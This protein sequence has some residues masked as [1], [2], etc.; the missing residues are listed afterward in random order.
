MFILIHLQFIIKN[1]HKKFM[2]LSLL[3]MKKKNFKVKKFL[4]VKYA[5]K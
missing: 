5:N 2:K 4:F 1:I 3:N